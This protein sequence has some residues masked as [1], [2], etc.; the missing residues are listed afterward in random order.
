MV[1]QLP[2]GASLQAAFSATPAVFLHFTIPIITIPLV[3]AIINNN[4]ITTVVAHLYISL[5][6]VTE[7]NPKCFSTKKKTYNDLV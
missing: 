7:L 3:T 1:P 6:S 2:A 5:Q 4:D